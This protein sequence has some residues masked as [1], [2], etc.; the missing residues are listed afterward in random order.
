MKKMFLLFT[1]A[2]GFGLTLTLLVWPGAGGSAQA[3]P[4]ATTW[5]VNGST[6]QDSNDCQTPATACKTI[7]AA[8]N[9]AANG[10]TIQIAAGTYV[11]NLTIRKSLTLVGAGQDQTI[12]DGNQA[13]RVLT[14]DWSGYTISVSGMTLRNGRITSG[15]GGGVYN[16]ATLT[17]DHVSILSNTVATVNGDGGGVHNRW[18]VITMTHCIVAYNHAEWLGG[19]VMND[20]GTLS[21][22]DSTLA[23]N[24]AA[25]K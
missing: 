20:F 21:I 24:E 12:V 19:G 14:T 23:Y 5:Y 13:G 9:K 6:G 4:S 17:L 18:G 25:N 11:E 1:V 7:G 8:V 3:A 15:Y 10:D 22:T 16:E 2:L